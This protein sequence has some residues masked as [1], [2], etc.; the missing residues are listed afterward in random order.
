[1]KASSISGGMFIW[2]YEYIQ[3]VRISAKSIV[4]SRRKLILEYQIY[5]WRFWVGIYSI[6]YNTQ[7]RK[8][9]PKSKIN[10]YETQREIKKLLGKLWEK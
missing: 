7:P 3:F 9:Q 6:H 8:D 5:E 10:A 2:I 4:M 1:M